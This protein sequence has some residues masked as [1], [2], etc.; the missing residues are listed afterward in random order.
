[1]IVLQGNVEA[2]GNYEEIQAQGV[3]LMEFIR[4]QSE[5]ED[6]VFTPDEGECAKEKEDREGER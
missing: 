6:E 3:E 4:P 1:M 2:Y 5:E